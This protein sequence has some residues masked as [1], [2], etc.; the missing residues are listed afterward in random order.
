M[1]SPE[2]DRLDAVLATMDR[3]AVAVSGGIDSLT[4]ATAAQRVL[5]GRATMHHATSPAVPAE[6]TQ[7]T[8]DIA[9]AQGWSLDVFDAGEFA[10]PEYR[11]NPANR[12]FFCKINLYGAV[13]A[14]TTDTIASG[15][16]LDDLGEYRPGLDAARRHGVRHPFVEAGLDKRMVR[17][18]ARELGLGALSELPA[19]PC[20]SSRIETGIRIEAD[21]LAMVHQAEKLVAAALGPRTVRCRVRKSGVVVE[22]DEAALDRLDAAQESRLRAELAGLAASAGIYRPISFAAYRTG[23][24]FLRA[25]A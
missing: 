23:S 21:M 3:L 2:L 25:G 22:L 9:A 11:A 17:Q 24:A 7:R 13:A 4:L 18:L 5:G 20:L 8:R 16:N 14:R 6:A 12:C 10:D 19:A 15:T 1:K